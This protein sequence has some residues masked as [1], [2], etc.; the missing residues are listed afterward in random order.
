[1]IQGDTCESGMFIVSSEGGRL[2][3]FAEDTVRERGPDTRASGAPACTRRRR[4]YHARL[5]G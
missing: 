4:A 2:G 5:V 1:M 3:V